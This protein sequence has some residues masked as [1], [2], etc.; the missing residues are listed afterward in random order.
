MGELKLHLRRVLL[1]VLS[2][3]LYEMFEVFK[4]DLE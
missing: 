1:I 2:P 3:T 4:I